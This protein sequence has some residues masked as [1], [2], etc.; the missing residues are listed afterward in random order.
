MFNP[1]D[2]VSW[3]FR[4]GEALGKIISLADGK[5]TIEVWRDRAPSGF[6]VT[7]PVDILNH[8][9]LLKI[10]VEEEEEDDD[11]TESGDFEGMALQPT[12]KQLAKLN[13]LIPDRFPRIE[14]HE[15]AI[16][17][18]VAADNLINRSRGK[19]DIAE[20][21]AMAKLM[22]GLPFTQDHD[23]ESVG[24]QIGVIFDAYIRT[25]DDTTLLG[26]AGN[27]KYNNKVAATEGIQQL[28]C[29][30][31]IP[32]ESD[33]IQ[34]MRMGFGRHVSCGGFMFADYHCPLCSTSFAD[35]KCPHYLPDMA[36]GVTEDTDPLVAPWYI[37]KGVF[38]MGELS[39]VLIPNLPG[40]TIT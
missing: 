6:Q 8:T 1:G 15:V 19:W 18:Y 23:W 38:D 5:A 22:P 28:V 37:R 12:A 24:K 2:F 3:Q 7:H 16:V 29:S 14:A 40:A 13:A 4:D 39:L 30:I 34:K 21:K 36:W 35:D 17:E 27:K 26:L 10:S 33:V 20:L 25:S 9:D 32:T 31:A 11:E